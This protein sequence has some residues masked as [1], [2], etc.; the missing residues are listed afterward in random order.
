M[1]YQ[2]I[3]IDRVFFSSNTY[4]FHGIIIKNVSPIKYQYQLTFCKQI[5]YKI[6]IGIAL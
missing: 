3:I 2:Q 4:V 1:I 6:K 5:F